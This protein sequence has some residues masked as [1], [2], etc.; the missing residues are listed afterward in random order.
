[1]SSGFAKD[2]NTLIVIALTLGTH[3][4][5]NQYKKAA[6]AIIKASQELAKTKGYAA[7]KAAVAGVKKAVDTK[8]GDSA[9]LK[10][11][12][13]AS[14]EQIMLAV[15]AINTQ[16]KRNIKLR[17]PKRDGPKAAGR[18]AVIAAIGQASLYHSDDT[19]KPE[20]AKEWYKYCQQMRSAA[21]EVNAAAHAGDKKIAKAAMKKLQQSC[22][23][24]HT[25]FHQEALGKEDASRKKRIRALQQ[26]N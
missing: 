16:L 23:D 11:Q 9:G 15:P 26:G 12:K 22:D 17:R 25:I 2:S 20:L 19:T 5:D 3:D 14:L 8:T 1:M 6:P 24:C 21:S 4:T 13:A 18:S 7:T 10:W